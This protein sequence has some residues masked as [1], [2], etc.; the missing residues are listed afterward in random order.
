LALIYSGKKLAKGSPETMA[1]SLLQ[2]FILSAII[3]IARQPP[4]QGDESS[5]MLSENHAAAL[6]LN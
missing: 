5:R 3:V 4:F 1:F 2:P 6:Q